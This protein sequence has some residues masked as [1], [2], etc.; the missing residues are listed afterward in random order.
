M[1]RIVLLGANGQ[2]ARDLLLALREEEVL[3]FTHEELDICDF[4]SV[5]SILQKSAPEVVINAAAIKAEACERFPDMALLVNALAP[6]NLATVCRDLD[7]LLV[8]YSSDYVFG[9]DKGG[10]YLE[11]DTPAPLNVYGVAKV[12]G[13]HLVRSAWPRH[14]IIRTSGLF[15][16]GGM[17]RGRGNFVETM[18]RLGGERGKVRVVTD[19]VFSPSY[20]PDMAER[21]REI[22][23]T[24]SLGT[25]HVTNSGTCSWFE[26][27]EA[28]L[29][30][31]LPHVQ[32][33]PVTT[34]EF[35]APTRRPAYSVLDNVRTRALGLPDLR[36]WQEALADYLKARAGVGVRA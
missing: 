31:A 10:P 18:L 17:G 22:I 36:P 11:E 6:R 32:V 28:I 20:A 30:S 7:A 12:A 25:F 16:V 29:G 34:K 35:G 26:F 21:T 4:Q 5:R 9:G 13:E 15:G 2:L 3:P 24:G 27:A 1:T 33:E 23:Q 8:H 14:C 19:Q